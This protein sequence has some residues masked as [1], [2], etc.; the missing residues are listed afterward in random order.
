MRFARLSE[1]YALS[2]LGFY[3]GTESRGF[4]TTPVEGFRSI[5]SILRSRILFWYEIS[6]RRSDSCNFKMLTE[7]LQFFLEVLL[8]VRW[9]L[10][11]RY[12]NSRLDSS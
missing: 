6:L 9:L 10:G 8:N 11:R 4:E 12:L 2:A 7:I 5:W 1:L 3:S